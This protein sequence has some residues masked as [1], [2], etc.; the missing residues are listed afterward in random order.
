MPSAPQYL[1]VV[2]KVSYDLYRMLLNSKY[3]IIKLQGQ[4]N[5]EGK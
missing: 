5:L 1:G 4:F 3:P 2:A